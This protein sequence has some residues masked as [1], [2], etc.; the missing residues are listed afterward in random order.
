MKKSNHQNK[1]LNGYDVLF[2][3]KGTQDNPGD[4]D[5][6]LLVIAAIVVGGVICLNIANILSIFGIL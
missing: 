5:G 6:L 4:P 2:H 1:E 3:K